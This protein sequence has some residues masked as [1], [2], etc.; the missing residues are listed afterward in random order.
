MSALPQRVIATGRWLHREYN[1]ARP[2]FVFF[3]VAFLLQL[4]IIKLAVA[5][6]SIPVTALSRAVVGALFAA[7]A[8][9]ILDETP[10]ARTLERYRRAIAVALKTLLY[11]FATLLLGFIERLLEGWHRVGSFDGGLS[12]AIHQANV[13]RFF[14]W[15]LGISLIFA[16]YFAWSEVNKRMGDGALWSLFFQRP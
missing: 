2:V 8:A 6:F 5:Q 16:I 7:K 1:A 4:L 15:V 3:L 11:G 9:L 14:A 10:L 13:Y 12:E